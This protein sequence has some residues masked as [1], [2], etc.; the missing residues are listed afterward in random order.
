MINENLRARNRKP[1]THKTRKLETI[2]TVHTCS[3]E[4]SL[5]FRFSY[6]F[7]KHLM[8]NCRLRTR[9]VLMNNVEFLRKERKSD[10]CAV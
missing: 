3:E 7:L 4:H 5:T 10:L 1:D 2:H 6:H 9:S 8:S